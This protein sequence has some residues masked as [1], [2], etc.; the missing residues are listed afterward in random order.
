MGRS[1]EP[2][3]PLESLDRPPS[4][5]DVTDASSST[6]V[7]SSI[8]GSWNV[9]LYN[10]TSGTATLSPSFTESPHQLYRLIVEQARLPP[11]QHVCIR[12]FKGKGK[13]DKDRETDFNFS[14]DLTPTLLR[15]FEDNSEWHELRVVRDGDGQK[16]FRGG[17]TES[18]HWVKPSCPKKLRETTDL[19]DG[20]EGLEDQS[21][22]GSS[23][24]GSN[25]G[26][27]TLMGWCERFCHDPAALKSYDRER[28]GRNLILT[29]V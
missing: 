10:G 18:L 22:L 19:E 21:L 2:D 17:I 12:G 1:S 11:Q 27:P 9:N 15:V 26:T 28:Y 5:N 24:D 16:V 4:Y 13:G 8:P 25:E 20:N 7:G 14:I 3:I 6:P 29:L 23:V